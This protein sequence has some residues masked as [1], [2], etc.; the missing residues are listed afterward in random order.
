MSRFN[1]DVYDKLFP[2]EEEVE[3]VETVVPTFT[4][5]EDRLDNASEPV[6]PNDFNEGEVENGNIDD[7]E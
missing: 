5:T 4:P 2:R 7:C 1:A 6:E 3:K